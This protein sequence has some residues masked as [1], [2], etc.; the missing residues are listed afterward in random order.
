MAHFK[1]CIY[2]I[3]GL[4]L[5]QFVN[6]Q[7]ENIR[8]QLVNEQK[9]PIDGVY[10]SI[11]DQHRF[12]YSDT[13]GLVIIPATG[14][15]P[16]DTLMFMHISYQPLKMAISSMNEEKI[17]QMQ[18]DIKILN[19]VVV[20]PLNP[21]ELVNEAIKRIPDLYA[22]LFKPSL[23]VHADIDIFDAN[24]ST[25]LIYYK[26]ALQFS[27]PNTQKRPVVYKQAEI[28]EIS[29]EA[30]NQL[31]PIR[32]SRFAEMIPID[33]QGVIVKSKEYNFDKYQYI[34]YRGSEAVQI[35]FH[36][37][38]GNFIQTGFLI[39]RENTKAIVALQ[40]STQPM[41]NVM[42]SKVKGGIRYTD[43]E[44]HKV[45]VTYAINADNLYE[46]ES[47]TYYVQYKNRLKNNSNSIILSSHLKKISPF[48]VL[49]STE[50]QIDKLFI[51]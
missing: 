6:G 29:K 18:S 12:W 19:E 43:L 22:P 21:N 50:I 35:N 24:D 45:N 15:S 3:I 28:E 31:Y 32:V 25:S 30:K 8:L 38:K 46:F 5:C 34:Q 26:G 27:Q 48:D 11:P 4:L 1:N 23:S 14:L 41:K 17:I 40:Y 20:K 13:L 33:E 37:K 10:V 9:L 51:E 39:I 2:F 7:Q 49:G 44:S 42:R 16:T 36:R 47:G